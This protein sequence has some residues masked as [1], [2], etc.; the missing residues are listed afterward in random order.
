MALVAAVGVVGVVGALTVRY[1]VPVCD[2]MRRCTCAGMWLGVML[3][4]R[5]RFSASLTPE[6]LLVCRR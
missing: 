5:F 2:R 6:K 1:A 4:G 3:K